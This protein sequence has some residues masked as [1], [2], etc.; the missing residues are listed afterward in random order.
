MELYE[1]GKFV[2]WKGTKEQGRVPIEHFIVTHL[3]KEVMSLSGGGISQAILKEQRPDL[4][5]AYNKY[6]AIWEVQLDIAR[7]ANGDI[8]D[9]LDRMVRDLKNSDPEQDE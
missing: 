9:E 8:L 2:K 5:E 4:I 6:G 3:F 1:K 7:W